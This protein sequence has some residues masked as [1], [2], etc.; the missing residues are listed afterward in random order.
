MVPSQQ[1][2][3][4]IETVQNHM[5]DVSFIVCSQNGQHAIWL[6]AQHAG[7]QTFW[8]VLAL[9][10]HLVQVVIVD[11][12]GTA[13]EVEACRSIAHRGVVLVSPQPAQVLH[14]CAVRCSHL[15]SRP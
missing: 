8:G 3:V 14:C 12:I 10:R 5:P 1:H 13:R 6:L 15:H 9:T 11:E 7:T 2:S 4:M